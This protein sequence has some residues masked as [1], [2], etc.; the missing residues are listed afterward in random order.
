MKQRLILEGN[1]A[2][3]IGEIWE[4]NFDIPVGFTERNKRDF[5]KIGNG[6]SGAIEELEVAL[7]ENLTNIGIIVDADFKENGGIAAR[8]QRISDVVKARFPKL[9]LSSYSP[10]PNGII[11]KNENYPTIGVWI[12]PDN[13]NEGYLEHF[14]TQLI[15]KEDFMYENATKTVKDLYENNKHL[16]EIRKQ[17]ANIYTWL[18]WQE[19]P[20]QSFG[21]AIKSNILNAKGEA[22]QP[23]LNWLK[24]TF[25]VEVKEKM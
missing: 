18:A 11:I 6:F 3:V 8:W 4:K 21:T 13:Q 5:A 19:E 10:N 25:D 23:F 20:G 14:L 15:D 16:K 1:E 17:K 22:I 9:D 2:Y 7:L 24:D 12:M